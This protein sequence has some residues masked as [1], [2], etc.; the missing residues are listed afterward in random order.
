MT[1]KGCGRKWRWPNCRYCPGICLDWL[2]QP[3]EGVQDR[4][5]PGWNCTRDLLNTKQEWYLLDR[6][7]RFLKFEYLLLKLMVILDLNGKI[8]FSSVMYDLRLSKRWLWIMSSCGMWRCV[9]LTLTDVPEE[10]IASVFSYWVRARSVA[11]IFSPPL[12]DTL[13]LIHIP[14]LPA[15]D[16]HHRP[17]LLSVVFPCG[18]LSL[19]PCSYVAGCFWVV[20]QS[21]AI[22]SRWFTARGFFYPEDGGDTFLRNIS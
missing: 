11:L 20:A 5:S 15:V 7:I 1:W 14:L 6:D 3:T 4:R 18:I 21:A 8:K 10:R 13:P 16:L 2:G 9:D 12:T 19:S 17:P 22:C